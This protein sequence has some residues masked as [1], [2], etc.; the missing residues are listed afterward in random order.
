M[1]VEYLIKEKEKR[2]LLDKDITE[3]IGCS[4]SLLGSYRAR[5]HHPGKKIFDK[6][7]DFFEAD[8][9]QRLEIWEYIQEMKRKEEQKEGKT[10]VRYAPKTMGVHGLSDEFYRLEAELISEFGSLLKV[11]ESNE[12]LIR[13][14]KIVGG[15]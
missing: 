2:G 15:T 9:K 6:L 12:K 11:P 1:F 13:I 7:M 4:P 8:E 14:K 3:A 10:P 5:I